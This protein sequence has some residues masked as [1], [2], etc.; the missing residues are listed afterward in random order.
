MLRKSVTAVVIVL[1]QIALLDGLQA[2]ETEKHILATVDPRSISHYRERVDQVA[3]MCGVD[4]AV[5]HFGL[6]R[7]R[8]RIA[9]ANALMRQ[10]KP[11]QALEQIQVADAMA[12]GVDFQKLQ[13]RT[14]IHRGDAIGVETNDLLILINREMVLAFD[15][16]TFRLVG[17]YDP[18][19]NK[20]YILTSTT[21]PA[22]DVIG[23][24]ILLRP[25]SERLRWR[26]IPVEDF[27]DCDHRHKWHT[28]PTGIELELSWEGIDT[29]S[30]EGWPEGD[31]PA[32][33]G[34]LDVV[35]RV[36][37]N[38]EGMSRWSC[39]IENRSPDLG[40]QSIEFPVLA[41]MRAWDEEDPVDFN[42]VGNPRPTDKTQLGGNFL[43][44]MEIQDKCSAL[45][46]GYQA[47]YGHQGGIYYLPEDSEYLWKECNPQTDG[48]SRTATFSHS[49]FTLNHR[50][51]EVKSF[52]A[53]YPVSVGIFHG[54]WY[55]AARIYRR[56]A[57]Q[58]PWCA[59]GTLAE[60][61]DLPDW[62]KE[63]EFFQQGGGGGIGPF[64]ADQRIARNYGRPVGIWMTHW[65]HYG[66]DN[67]YPDYFPPRIGEEAFK[68][69]IAHGR[70]LG[71]HYMPY[72]NVNHYAYDAP[73]QSPAVREAGARF[74]W[75]PDRTLGMRFKYGTVDMHAM[76]MCPATKIWQDKV[77]ENV[78]KLIQKYDCD[79]IYFDTLD[80]YCMQCSHPDHGH[81][82]GGGNYWVEGV[83]E[84]LRRA[85]R[86]SMAAG[87]KVA[88]S[89]EFWRERY[90]GDYDAGLWLAEYGTNYV[91]DVVY[92]DYLTTICKEW[93]GRPVV[94]YL[95]SVFIAGQ[96]QGPLGLG[97]KHL[98]G[99]TPDE[100]V[101]TFM[102]Y[103]SDCR[104]EFGMK[105][106][107]LGARLRNP[108]VRTDLPTVQPSKDG[109]PLPAVIT[110][111][112]QAG[113]GNI[114][115]FYMNIS[116]ASQEFIYD[117]DLERFE[118]YEPLS[119]YTV[120]KYELGRQSFLA[121]KNQGKLTG[122]DTLE[123]GKMMMIQFSLK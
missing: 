82:Q 117:I 68:Q 57:I 101:L 34:V 10:G 67:K 98:S 1:M 43:G 113:D 79:G 6:R 18:T 60:R 123:H 23:K 32:Q 75:G 62:F 118:L 70:E 53:T 46:F 54:D 88:F 37:M 42:A 26:E 86:E 36:S 77:S 55:T 94:P 13:W 121:K 27:D 122:T 104:H 80:I 12:A 5:S 71:L 108:G 24:I 95:G 47:Y 15:R 19:V 72:I 81:P 100:E 84:I 103:L 112:Y 105:Y 39:R 90:I 58:Q 119:T 16:P 89:G 56:W 21:A 96:T 74:V 83:R 40:L 91:R 28:T 97:E 99:E 31:M 51:E 29:P 107:N 111:A 49:Y 85:R 35:G 69:M 7:A 87:K 106:V 33:P 64:E 116:D 2:E 92:H 11:K 63:R 44:M 14:A 45:R 115:C 3:R 20:E 73:S 102:H 30:H 110:S 120:T 78:R 109:T 93:R 9:D 52:E 38:S 76:V 114:G 50:G 25:N 22:T 59:K 17:L 61:D 8:A 41:D 66:F 48:E 65:M 4:Q